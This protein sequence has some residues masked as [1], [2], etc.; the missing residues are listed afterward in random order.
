MTQTVTTTA[1][2]FL[3]DLHIRGVHEGRIAKVFRLLSRT[4][5]CALYAPDSISLHLLHFILILPR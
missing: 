1:Q 3:A 2:C 5:R 4:F